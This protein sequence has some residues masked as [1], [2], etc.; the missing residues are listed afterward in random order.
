MKFTTLSSRALALAVAKFA[1]FPS[2]AQANDQAFLSALQTTPHNPGAAFQAQH[3]L[4]NTQILP[5]AIPMSSTVRLS[6]VA[7]N[8]SQT[9][10]TIVEQGL[11]KQ[12]A[13]NGSLTEG[14]SLAAYQVQTTGHQ[15]LRLDAKGNIVGGSFII[16]SYFGQ[17]TEVLYIPK[18][19][20]AFDESTS[21]VLSGNIVNAGQLIIEN[22]SSASATI[23]AANIVN[24]GSIKS[25]VPLTLSAADTLTNSGQIASQS[26]LSISAGTALIN[27][28]QSGTTASINALHDI[29]ISASKVI[30]AGLITS[31]SGNINLSTQ[32]PAD[33]AIT[34]TGGA[35]QATSGDVNVRTS[36]FAGS[37]DFKLTGGDVYARNLN[38]YSGCGSV[39]INA[40]NISGPVN[41]TAGDLHSYTKSPN[42]QLG[43]L[44]VSGDPT[45]F[46]VGSIS[47][48]GGIT[49][50]TSGIAIIATGDI[51][52]PAGSSP[53][54]TTS[55]S[56][57]SSFDIL[58]AAGAQFTPTTGTTGNGTSTGDTTTTVTINGGS[59]TGGK[60][61]FGNNAVTVTTV[62]TNTTSNPFNGGNVT[63]LAF[64]G[65]NSGSGTIYM[66]QTTISTG[67]AAGTSSGATFSNGNVVLAGGAS[68]GNAVVAGTI[69]TASSQAAGNG[70]VTIMAASP[71]I[72]TAI[73]VLNGGVTNAGNTY[74]LGAI[75]PANIVL[76]GN[77]NT[78][79]SPVTVAAGGTVQIGGLISTGGSVAG[80][81]GGNVAIFAG[82]NLIDSNQSNTPGINTSPAGVISGGGAGIYGGDVILVAGA[83]LSYSQTPALSLSVAGSPEG[84][85]VPLVVSGPSSSGGN[86]SFNALNFID[87]TGSAPLVT[88]LA[89]S[90]GNVTIVALGASS[91]SGTTG[92]VNL[93]SSANIKT[94]GNYTSNAF[95]TDGNVSI[96][97]G[98][99]T[100]N[101]ISVGAIKT[102]GTVF[103]GSTNTASAGGGNITIATSQAI[104]SLP[105]SY[106]FAQQT[107]G[108][109]S[110]TQSGAFSAGT[111]LPTSAVVGSLKAAGG[112]YAIGNLPLTTTIS[113]TSGGNLTLGSV[114][115]QA[116]TIYATAL[117]AVVVDLPSSY[118]NLSAGGTMNLSGG[119]TISSQPGSVI[120]TGIDGGTI[121]LTAKQFNITPGI[122]GSA[123]A[124]QA[125]GTNGYNAGDFSGGNAGSISIT[126]TG[127]GLGASVNI[128]DP[129]A[130]GQGNFT[131]AATSDTGSGNG[132]TLLVKSG[133]NIYVSPAALNL[134]PQAGSNNLPQLEGAPNPITSSG[135]GANITL[136]AANKDPGGSQSGS[137]YISAT[138]NA[139]GAASQYTGASGNPGGNGGIISITTNSATAFNIGEASSSA[140][141]GVAGRL[142]ANGNVADPG[143]PNS[144]GA[145][146]SGGSITVVNL[147]GAITVG[148]KDGI[149]A[150][151]QVQA[152]NGDANYP[153]ANGGHL[154]LQANGAVLSLG[155]ID[156]SAGQA[157]QAQPPG[158]GGYVE[159]DTNSKAVFEVGSPVTAQT[160]GVI[161]TITAY[162]YVPSAALPTAAPANQIANNIGSGGTI[163]LGNTGIGGIRID[164][165]GGTANVAVNAFAANAQ[166]HSSG[167][168]GGT[169]RLYAPAGNVVVNAP[170]DVSG[171]AQNI[172]TQSLNGAI[173]PGAQSFSVTDASGYFLG[174]NVWLTGT[175]TGVSIQE[176]LTVTAV[177]LATNTVTVSPVAN[178]YDG[179]TA[180]LQAYYNGGNGGTIEITANG[181]S[182]PFTVNASSTANGVS[183]TLKANGYSAGT[184]S[185]TNL[186]AGGISIAA[187]G[188]SASTDPVA[189]VPNNLVN[190]GGTGGNISLRATAGP[191]SIAGS[192][193]VRGMSGSGVGANGANYAGSGGNILITLNSGSS[194]PFVIGAGA[195]VPANGVQTALIA[196]GGQGNAGNG[197]AGSI[198]V[199]NTGTGGMTVMPGSISL[200]TYNN[201][202]NASTPNL[203]GN[204]GTLALESP[205]GPVT[206]NTNLSVNASAPSATF[207][208]GL[209][210]TITIVANNGATP[211]ALTNGELSATGWNGG[212]ITVVN[213][214]A[215]GI[216]V[217]TGAINVTA[218]AFNPSDTQFRVNGGPGGN[219]SLQAPNGPV[220]ITG[221]L[222]ANGGAGST[223]IDSANGGNATTASGNPVTITGLSNF[224]GSFASNELVLISGTVGGVPMQ[225][226]QNVSSTDNSSQITVFHLANSYDANSITGAGGYFGGNGGQISIITKTSVNNPFQINSSSQ[227]SAVAGGIA[228]NGGTISIVNT[229]SGGISIN[230]QI[231][232][233]TVAPAAGSAIAAGGNGGTLTL[234]ATGSSGTILISGGGLNVD[235]GTEYTNSNTDNI[236]GQGGVIA[237]TVNSNS[238]AN[239][240]NIG[241]AA[242]N[243]VTGTL[244]AVGSNGGAVGVVNLGTGGIVFNPTN[245]VV[246][247]L[248][249]S[250][251]YSAGNGGNI[252]LASTAKGAVI[253]TSTAGTLAADSAASTNVTGNGG[254]IV[255]NAQTLNTSSGALT[256]SAQGLSTGGAAGLISLTQANSA[257]APLTIGGSGI[258]IAMTSATADGN[259]SIASA[260]GIILAG[261]LSTSGVS[262][263]TIALSTSGQGTIS[264]GGTI[265]TGAL[266]LSGGRGAL[267]T[268]QA[269]LSTVVGA[270][271]FTMTG[272][273]LYIA[274]ASGN[275]LTLNASSNLDS[276]T[277]GTV[278]VT[279]TSDI[280]VVGAVVSNG[281]V[282]LSTGGNIV[283]GANIIGRGGITLDA[284]Q[285]GSNTAGAIMP[286]AMALSTPYLMAETGGVTLNTGSGGIQNI[287][288]ST[289]TLTLNVLGDGTTAVTVNNAGNVQLSLGTSASLASIA[290]TNSLGSIATTG[291]INASTISLTNS[292][293]SGRDSYS[294]TLGGAVGSATTTSVTIQAA[295]DIVQSAPANVVTAAAI[296]LSSQTGNI[297]TLAPVAPGTTVPPASTYTPFMID[298][299]SAGGTLA[300]NV[301]AN[302]GYITLNT[303]S[304]GLVNIANTGSGPVALAG[305][306]SAGDFKLASA[307]DI[308]VISG[309]AVQSLFGGVTLHNQ[310]TSS[311][312]IDI[313]GNITGSGGPVIVQND[314]TAGTITVENN[315]AI[316][317]SGRV[318]DYQGTAPGLQYTTGVALISGPMP[319]SVAQGTIPAQVAVNIDGTATTILPTTGT[320]AYFGSSLVSTGTTVNL[321][322]P[323]NSAYA[324]TVVFNGATASTIS[325]GSNTTIN[326]NG[327]VQAI[328]NLDL[329]QASVKTA[330]TNL[331]TIS[332]SGINFSGRTLTIANTVSLENLSAF[333]IVSGYTVNLKNFQAVNPIAV[334]IA[335][336]SKALIAGTLQFSAAPPAVLSQGGL[337]VSAINGKNDSVLSISGKLTSDGSL[338]I[339]TDGKLQISGTVSAAKNGT[340]SLASG[341]ANTGTSKT[342]AGTIS[343]TGKLSA[344]TAGDTGTIVIDSTGS[345]LQSAGSLSASNVNIQSGGKSFS[346]APGQISLKS[347]NATV[348]SIVDATAAPTLANASSI[349]IKEAA[350]A[351]FGTL[352]FNVLS[353]PLYVSPSS[354]LNISGQSAGTVEVASRNAINVVGPV[355]ADSLNLSTTGALTDNGGAI[356]ISNPGG[357]LNLTAGPIT[358]NNVTISPLAGAVTIASSGAISLPDT[359]I[360]LGTT[361]PNYFSGILA[362][363]DISTSGSL[364]LT[365]R[366]GDIT[367]DS[368]SQLQTVG[369]DLTMTASKGNLVLDGQFTA[370]GGN[371]KMLASAGVYGTSPTF[372]ADAVGTMA[373]DARGGGIEIG[374][375]LT[376]STQL[377]GAFNLTPG[378][379]LALPTFPQPDGSSQPL[380]RQTMINNLVGFTAASGAIVQNSSAAGLVDLSTS[381][382]SSPSV[383]S[384]PPTIGQ[385]AAQLN[386]FGGAMVF[387]ALGSS[388]VRFN[389]STFN[390]NSFTLVSYETAT[391]LVG[392]AVEIDDDFNGAQVALAHLFSDTGS[393]LLTSKGFENLESEAK[394]KQHSKTA[395]AAK[396]ANTPVT[397]RWHGGNQVVH[398]LHDMNILT[399]LAKLEV[400]RGATFILGYDGHDLRLTACSSPG[401]VRLASLEGTK[402][403]S[404]MIG[405]EVTVSPRSLQ[406][407]DM[408]LDDGIGRRNFKRSAFGNGVSMASC[409][410][411]MLALMS[412]SV[413]MKPIRQQQSDVHKRLAY[414]MIKLT[415]ILE[416][417]TRS[418]GRY[419][420]RKSVPVLTAN[421][422]I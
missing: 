256:L 230:N 194:K 74:S 155:S 285:G 45:F 400:K 60:I 262:G 146:G 255:I 309:A 420:L 14:E 208:Q 233:L 305:I 224:A 27:A 352:T 10:I 197:N 62:P 144:V 324:T 83:A 28:A 265:T 219:I 304:A 326:S 351:N 82:N 29:N 64:A 275:P 16:P 278:S 126:T 128:G 5:H 372:T 193:D 273:S 237:I 313:A 322:N 249:S 152:A 390:T 311:G 339:N 369:G 297:G 34:N 388:G 308:N 32:N 418:H 103:T 223:T 384:I 15:T 136:I 382:G 189:N 310:S 340:L 337:Y 63:M 209:A 143:T 314:N 296:V 138:L 402:S 164:S 187:A 383:T 93:A 98:A 206:I 166:F 100:G 65:T 226:Y 129:L 243:G 263:G 401:D 149:N 370:A 220:T 252:D 373:T 327:T 318:W 387:D 122:G 267:G 217:A 57:G 124:I 289:N 323:E 178:T 274:N 277:P 88:S 156:A 360:S 191:V 119:S 13:L 20:K 222:A 41:V 33:I 107:S 212:N 97:A 355:T 54:L 300:V 239:A 385:S 117:G 181:G 316:N 157:G 85:N 43:Q 172:F 116:N 294:I 198:T 24:S 261:P 102:A 268:S 319:T 306:L 70:S 200:L 169:I 101:A 225:E 135:T 171:G 282:L 379:V 46:N 179:A 302:N 53:T 270:L 288:T 12:I 413:L 81:A 96:F 195:N 344:G 213:N 9:S 190:F 165:S 366:S 221:Q 161:G 375:G 89:S 55:N 186:G 170:L 168:D 321:N 251:T 325:L 292:T 6:H 407:D 176:N 1:L 167:G 398:A 330:L 389:G 67:G 147:G 86:I 109:T 368:G 56:V 346:T 334:N 303:P 36:A 18:G 343:L 150:N 332:N 269:P 229:G 78:S 215:G 410:V 19:V 405:Q 228:G 52:V 394:S 257:A 44:T 338:S 218:Q 84:I 7:P 307:S 202:L 341:A 76:N 291:A 315:V 353:S 184:V 137:V 415:A 59:T 140:P 192:L 299:G 115:N 110:I 258:T 409:E 417:L 125:S 241:A 357:N 31:T 25:L 253:S 421:A 40:D 371:I 347:I 245:I 367:I 80:F 301:F 392:A 21:L 196:D 182:S 333:N 260:A 90:G 127:T 254:S 247:A 272:G 331:S 158:N 111:L 380:G 411:S 293:S 395:S 416:N 290:F 162:G 69:N 91:G 148:S 35:L 113:V 159:I 105:F 232:N 363:T 205:K 160:N 22:P 73:Q 75:Q 336:T 173:S 312:N 414:Q 30:N 47:I 66:P 131:I 183:G 374:S 404:L 276:S 133:G 23:D 358:F 77:I 163:V 419:Q 49:S 397:M 365:S 151:L 236:A 92:V 42:L 403:V 244:S 412:R 216:T 207:S 259:I 48:N 2:A 240:F 203:P 145:F 381:A 235:G 393:R 71:Q 106:E 204:G 51:K 26:S 298:L 132:G 185:V 335:G 378:T 153:G 391:P 248:G 354:A 214:G 199:V 376:S 112:A 287:N 317:G 58:L 386:L 174:Q 361:G 320:T 356:T 266:T 154:V 3:H 406:V 130:T 264:G 408:M 123:V 11:H 362:P 118:I 87:T 94:G 188:I 345:I 284:S 210:G 175:K 279:S 120:S 17:S 359:S 4:A 38:I 37:N 180:T 280:N 231:A 104:S 377:A 139:S 364:S 141:N 328:S 72:S 295:G 271:T 246:T 227:L 201:G 349:L 342:A 399:S 177:N 8:L 283:L 99:P 61:D 238:I 281:A 134:A 286:D 348:L 50:N 350:A 68:S 108:G 79:A 250:N 234:K 39:D 121:A 142:V 211:L 114:S 329:S 242:T 396:P 95:A 422:S